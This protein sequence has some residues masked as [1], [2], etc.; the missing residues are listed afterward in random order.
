MSPNNLARVGI[1]CVDGLGMPDDE[2]PFAC[3]LVN[4]RRRV[5]RFLRGERAPEFLAGVLVKSDSD[6]AV[7]ARKADEFLPVCEWM[8]CESPHGRLDTEVLFEIARPNQ[9]SLSG[10]ETKQ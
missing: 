6:T 4:H 10:L 9:R 5:A 2:L 7:P 3:E 8:G 1:E